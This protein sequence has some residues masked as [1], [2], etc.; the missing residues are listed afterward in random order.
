M[1]ARARAHVCLLV[2]SADILTRACLPVPASLPISRSDQHSQLLTY[3]NENGPKLFSKPSSSG[4][5]PREPIY[6]WFI[7]SLVKF[8]SESFE[9]VV[10]VHSIV[11]NNLE[12]P[13]QREIDPR[14]SSRFT[15]YRS[16]FRETQTYAWY[17]ASRG[18]SDSDLVVHRWRAAQLSNKR[19]V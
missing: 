1:R 19:N 2:S 6:P 18:R 10:I 5:S 12:F 14:K 15:V 13:I 7:A 9:Y 11:R 3:E 4:C 8:A 17:K 16:M